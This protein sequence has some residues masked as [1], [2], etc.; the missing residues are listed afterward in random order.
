MGI[1]V[2]AFS[3]GWG[4]AI[5]S[6]KI[7]KVEYRIGM[8]PIGGY[9]RMRGEA[10]FREALSNQKN[11]IPRDKGTF[12]GATPLRRISVAFAG[13]AANAF[14]AIIVL[15]FV[16]G[17]GFEVRTLSNRIVLASEIDKAGN[18]P[19]DIAGLMTGDRI[20]EVNGKPISNYQEIQESI[21]P[22]AGE[23]LRLKI[24]RSGAPLA[25]DIVPKLDTETGA[26]KIGVYFWTDP[27]VESVEAGSAAA[28]AGVK[29][30][31]ILI[32][33]NSFPLRN[34]VD[35]SM[36]LKDKPA[37]LRIMVERAGMISEKTMVLSWSE[38]GDADL[39]IDFSSI[40][41]RTPK[42]SIPQAIAKGAQETW[43]TFTLSLRGISLLF[44]GVNL[45][46]AVSGP[47]RITYMVGDVAAE[48]FDTSVG[49]GFSALGSFLALLSVALFI[50]NLLP[51]PA[52]DGGLIVL[53]AFEFLR[54]KALHPKIIYRFQMV[55]TSL[56]FGLLLFSLFG[57]I[58]FLLG[59]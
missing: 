29:P 2:E 55:G 42:L 45:T 56:I 39:G 40:R 52:L 1:D 41:F 43:K 26:G 19:A 25:V 13:P 11:E 54:R 37:E 3:V 24:V 9:C 58:L 18:Y 35:L 57:D 32:S 59:R 7:G 14:F 20:V 48:G 50:M 4:K 36:A 22:Y 5:W 47:V 15:S 12:Y 10:E 33:A 49:A 17:F 6:R 27:L 38:K 46:K 51:I 23:K 28:I 16:W 31:D 21:A 8:L 34:S 30:G 44:R 53:F